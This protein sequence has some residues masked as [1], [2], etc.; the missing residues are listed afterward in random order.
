MPNDRTA[1]AA[2]EASAAPA[3]RV[4]GLC[5]KRAC[6]GFTGTTPQLSGTEEPVQEPNKSRGDGTL[7]EQGTYDRRGRQL[8]GNRPVRAR[9]ALERA[10]VQKVAVRSDGT[11]S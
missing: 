3:A 5:L 11:I 10:A 8:E 1:A 2:P 9:E 4:K 6:L 7:P